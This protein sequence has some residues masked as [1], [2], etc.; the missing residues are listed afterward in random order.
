VEACGQ[1]CAV[2]M[3]ALKHACALVCLLQ[4]VSSA[5]LSM[6]SLSELWLCGVRFSALSGLS[7][8]LARYRGHQHLHKQWPACH[9]QGL[10][11]TLLFVVVPG[12]VSKR[13]ASQQHCLLA[14][15]GQLHSASQPS[16]PKTGCPASCWCVCVW[17]LYS[18]LESAAVTGHPR[19]RELVVEACPSLNQRA[20]RTCANLNCIVEA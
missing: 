15:S 18:V 12:M 14:Y 19:L 3:R 1:A 16:C 7:T 2:T 6:P 8:C 4:E 5:L 11:A 17:L 9:M 10:Q 13:P 20:V